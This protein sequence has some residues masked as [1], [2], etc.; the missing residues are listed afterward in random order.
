MLP[1]FA[2]KASWSSSFDDA[3]PHDDASRFSNVFYPTTAMSAETLCDHCQ[4]ID[5][6]NINARFHDRKHQ[7]GVEPEECAHCSYTICDLGYLEPTSECHLCQ[8]LIRITTGGPFQFASNKEKPDHILLQACSSLSL[9]SFKQGDT[10]HVKDTPILTVTA[11]CNSKH[12][13]R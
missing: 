7:V 6:E 12:H 2:M 1:A 3:K 9:L 5:F 4:E 10:K 8:F 11:G 13:K